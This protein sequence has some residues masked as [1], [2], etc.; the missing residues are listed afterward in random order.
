MCRV[1]TTRD[2]A[3]RGSNGGRDM[4]SPTVDRVNQIYRDCLKAL[5][6]RDLYRVYH[7]RYDSI[8]N[9]TELG[10]VITTA[11]TGSSG[12][13]T[14]K[15]PDL[16]YLCAALTVGSII[17]AGVKRHYKLQEKLN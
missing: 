6:S 12:L 9:R 7:D 3:Y 11:L 14:L 13:A 2:F 16:A 1:V 5:Y 4:D 15:I 10:G 8:L 17:S